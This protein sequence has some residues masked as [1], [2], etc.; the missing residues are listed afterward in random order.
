MDDEGIRLLRRWVEWSPET[1][2]HDGAEHC[3]YCGIR[4]PLYVTVLNRSRWIRTAKNHN[5]KC[6]YRKTKEYLA[7][8]KKEST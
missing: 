1:F 6:Q 5:P 8:V 2:T 4:I 7:K 3:R